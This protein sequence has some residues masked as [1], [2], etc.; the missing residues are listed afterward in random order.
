MNQRTRS[1][2]G[3]GGRRAPEAVD[4]AESGDAK[5]TTTDTSEHDAREG[6][7][8]GTAESGSDPARQDEA[9]GAMGAERACW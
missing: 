4:T 1:T 9:R 8:D 3:T 7:N 6:G 5:T 2:P